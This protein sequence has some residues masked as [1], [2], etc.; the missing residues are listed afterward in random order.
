MSTYEDD[1]NISSSRPQEDNERTR[2]HQSLSSIIDSFV[3]S[4]H[5]HIESLP[6]TQESQIETFRNALQ[7]L[8]AEEGS[9]LATDLI[10]VLED[11]DFNPKKGLPDD[12]LDTLDRVSLKDLTPEDDC[13]IC[14]NRFVEDKYPLIVKLPCNAKTKHR[15]HIFDLE[16][17]GPWLKM[18]ATCP[19]C[20]FDLSELNQKR[21]ERLAEELRLIKEQEEEEE[22]E[23]WDVYG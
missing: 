4:N 18:N 11:Q 13:P 23:D 22:E 8:S 9:T 20:R 14:T 17:I 7:V 16:C 6:E 1:H 19:L 10:G 15:G 12:Y 3:T 2:T 5:S 21:K